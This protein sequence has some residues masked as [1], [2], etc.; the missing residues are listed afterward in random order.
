MEFLQ[1]WVLK[2]LF[3]HYGIAV[4]KANSENFSPHGVLNLC[5][6]NDVNTAKRKG[7]YR[8]TNCAT[9]ILI[10]SLLLKK[11]QRR[12]VICA[13]YR[14]KGLFLLS[15][16]FHIFCFGFRQ[17]S[18]KRPKYQLSCYVTSKKIRQD[19]DFFQKIQQS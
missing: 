17:I 9:K 4:C 2:S 6:P 13:M 18:T 7:K 5:G 14:K 8:A 12:K 11:K 3:A 16:S 19:S 10:L 15:R 1:W